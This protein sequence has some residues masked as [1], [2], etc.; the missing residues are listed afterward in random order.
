MYRYKWALLHF[1]R[2]KTLPWWHAT[3]SDRQL[4]NGGIETHKK[5]TMMFLLF[6]DLF[7]R[8][9]NNLSAT[10]STLHFWLLCSHV[11]HP[12]RKK[13]QRPNSVHLEG[14]PRL[15]LWKNLFQVLQPRRGCEHQAED[16]PVDKCVKNMFY[17]PILNINKFIYKEVFCNWFEKPKLC[18]CF[19]T[20]FRSLGG[21]LSERAKVDGRV[22]SSGMTHS[23]LQFT[24][25]KE[26]EQLLLLTAVQ[27]SF[28]Y[29]WQ[30]LIFV[31]SCTTRWHKD[32][33]LLRLW[34]FHHD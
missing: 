11:I 3:I 27:Y 1:C 23:G 30:L 21:D 14:M 33:L 31:G 22:Y 9:G 4:T 17:R 29:K 12:T 20:Y 19:V 25:A 32:I 13:L 6:S 8:D 10:Y 5:W 34:R 15:G 26:N 16:K 2:L 24:V 7:K 18:C 28:A